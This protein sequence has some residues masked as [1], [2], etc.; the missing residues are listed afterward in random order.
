MTSSRAVSKTNSRSS[1][2]SRVRPHDRNGIT[3][4]AVASAH[5]ARLRYVTATDQPG[6]TRRRRGR[7]FIYLDA[8]G[9]MLRDRPTLDR[10][11]SLAI[12]PAWKNVWICPQP[13]GHLQA[14]GRDAR[15][16][17]QYRYHS[18]YREIRDQ[19]KFDRMLF[20]GSALPK[21]RRR[22]RRDLGLK[23]I[24]KQK[25]VAAVVRLLDQ[26]GAR[27]GNDEYKRANGSFGLTT[28]RNKHVE[29]H[30][31]ELHFHF[32]GKSGQEQDLNVSDDR[33]ARIVKHCQDLPGKELFQY[34]SDSGDFQVITS[35]DVNDY[36]R[37]ITGDE[38]T[39]KDFRT[40]HG[41]CQMLAELVELG[42]AESQGA[43][44]KNIIAATKAT[45][46]SLGNRPATC[47][48]YYIHPAVIESYLTGKTL[49]QIAEKS[50]HSAL[51][52]HEAAF[53]HLLH[54]IQ[55]SRGGSRRAA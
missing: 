44:K 9:R 25:I 34:R 23:G 20:F 3:T 55:H 2:P 29:I 35:G 31:A 54:Q 12:P 1:V 17:K 38:V 33:L 46:S 41:S 27:I 50:P 37:E 36:L 8:G 45:A 11:R 30:G 24:P 43:A 51:R 14:V 15:G 5:D 18:R 28:L 49:S 48:K 22:I 10:I 4:D 39:A 47:R 6:I 52:G 42:S 53:L 13:T 21:I 19:V 26:T 16:R 7:G 32:R 40:W